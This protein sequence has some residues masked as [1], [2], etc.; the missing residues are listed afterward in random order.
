[1]LSH[2]AKARG[3]SY[4]YA[5]KAFVTLKCLQAI[6]YLYGMA[7][8]ICMVHIV[9]VSFSLHLLHVTILPLIDWADFLTQLQYNIRK[10]RQVPIIWC[11]PF[12]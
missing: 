3:V 7:Y 2:V 8:C 1:M 11:S 5:I 4:I 9:C 12:E 6:F 10:G